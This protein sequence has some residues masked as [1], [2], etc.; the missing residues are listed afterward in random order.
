MAATMTNAETSPARSGSVDTLLLSSSPTFSAEGVSAWALAWT[1][2]L[3]ADICVL[4]VGEA[5]D[6]DDDA[7]GEDFCLG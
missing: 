4:T 7:V 2:L 3:L 1:G 6:V 5:D